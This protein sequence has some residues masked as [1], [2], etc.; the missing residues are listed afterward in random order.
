[1]DNLVSAIFSAD[2]VYSV[3]RLTT[4]ILLAALAALVTDRAGVMNIGLEG[5]MLSSALMGVIGSAYLH[6]AFLGLICAIITGMI[7]A[8]IM[9]YFAL[10]LDTDIILT[11]IAINLLASGGTVFLLYSI[12]RDKGMSTSLASLTLPTVRLPII[13]KIPVLGEMLSNHN[14]LTYFAIILVFV[15]WI[16]LYKTPLGLRIRIVGENPNAA[17]SVGINVIRIKYYAL[18]MSGFLASIG[19]AYM[20][21]GYMDKFARDM[22]AGRGFIALAA[23]ALGRGTPFGT[24]LS[25]IVFGTADAL[26][27]NL[28]ILNIPAQFIQ[29]IPY[30]FTIVG[31]VMYSIT[32]EKSLKKLKIKNINKFEEENK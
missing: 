21:M 12:C 17:E 18:L 3:F 20:S 19:G 32:K 24:L 4:P 2:F 13:D 14:I 6:S 15:V 16:M 10:N 11:G 29:M 5:I 30:I 25:S 31:L 22:T 28:Q 7:I 9:A 26:A 8:A 1:M 27:S 23:E